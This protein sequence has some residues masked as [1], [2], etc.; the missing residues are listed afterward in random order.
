MSNLMQFTGKAIKNLFSKPATTKYPYEPKIYPERTRGHIEITMED[1]VLCGMCMRNCPP[2]AI[3]VSRAAG[4]WEIMPFDCIQCGY[5]V[6]GCPKKCLRIVPGYTEPQ[7]QKSA[8]VHMKPTA[9]Q[10]TKDVL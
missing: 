10:T 6:H 7:P 5:C 2:G 8:E 4:T 1:C 9:M 3:K